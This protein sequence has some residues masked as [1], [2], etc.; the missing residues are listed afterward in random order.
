M[1]IFLQDKLDELE[2][3]ISEKFSVWKKPSDLQ[4]TNVYA[5]VLE[6]EE[7]EESGEEPKYHRAR[8]IAENKDVKTKLLR[9]FYL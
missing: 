5:C 8:V 3:T 4:K 2:Q 6:E 1:I 9:F 7:E